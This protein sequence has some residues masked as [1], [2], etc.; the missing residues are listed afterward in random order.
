VFS[1]ENFGSRLDQFVREKD[2]GFLSYIN[3]DRAFIEQLDM[4]FRARDVVVSAYFSHLH[5]HS[6]SEWPEL[7]YF[8]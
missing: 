2:F 4:P 1:P 3:A 6:T 8:G 7:V 5:S